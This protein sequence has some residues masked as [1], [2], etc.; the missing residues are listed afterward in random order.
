MLRR[1]ENK[2][3]YLVKLQEFLK[4]RIKKWRLIKVTKKITNQNSCH[5][6]RNS[7]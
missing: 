3:G 6:L 5:G 7:K 1:Q 4:M 2:L